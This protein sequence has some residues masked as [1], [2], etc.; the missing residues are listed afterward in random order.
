MDTDLFTFITLNF[1]RKRL[2]ID[3]WATWCM[4][5]KMEFKYYDSSFYEFMKEH[6]I[7]TVFISI[8]KPDRREK[9]KTEIDAINLK[10]YH[11]FAGQK[12]Q[13]SIKEVIFNDQTTVIPRYVLVDENG[14]IL[15]VDFNR[16]SDSYFKA[17][18]DKLLSD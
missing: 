3:L 17:A 2:F 13:A 18:I 11:V 15:S 5:C 14:K 8:D 7:Q 1:P 16:P 6:K 9:W 4:P 12:L 10:G